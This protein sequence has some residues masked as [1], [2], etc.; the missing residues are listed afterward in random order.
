MWRRDVMFPEPNQ[1][2]LSGKI[3]RY[4]DLKIQDMKKSVSKDREKKT[5]K[6]RVEK[7]TPKVAEEVLSKAEP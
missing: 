7:D 4:F 6:E 1:A 2:D 3:I 5:L